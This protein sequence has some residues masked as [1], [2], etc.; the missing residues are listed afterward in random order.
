[1]AAV[2][3]EAPKA[4]ATQPTTQPA[5]EITVDEIVARTNFSAYYQGLDGRAHVKMT[6][7]PKSG[8]KR[9]REMV[10]LRWDQPRP[11]PKTPTT[12]PVKAPPEAPTTRPV[13]DHFT[14]EQKFYV[15]FTSPADVNKTAFLVWKH[16]TKDDDRWMYIPALDNI[17]RI[18]ATDKRTSFVGSHFFYEDVSGRNI[19]DDVHE[20]IKTTKSY[21]VLK[22]TPRKAKASEAGFAYYTMYI[23]KKD[24]LPAYIYYY[25]AR[26]KKYRTYQA[27]KVEKVQGYPTVT[28]AK[29]ID[30]RTGDY[31][32]LEYRKVK[33]NLKVPEALFTERF[34]KRTPYKYLKD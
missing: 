27:M 20:L 29:M 9:V 22:N 14:G 23:T 21:Y 12:Q 19:N 17:K 4:P 15:Y 3:A 8:A 7:V 1:V 10:I 33:Y 6:I 24:F 32:L 31:T 34:L 30:E 2:R 5:E 26:G 11:K 13:E 25:D 28:K 16:L 18:A